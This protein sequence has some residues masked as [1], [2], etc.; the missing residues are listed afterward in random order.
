MAGL[1]R[2]RG[3]G[4]SQVHRSEKRGRASP[5]SRGWTFVEDMCSQILAG[6]PALAGMDPTGYPGE[7]LRSRLPRARGDGPRPRPRQR[8]ISPAS[9]RSRGWTRRRRRPDSRRRGF[10][11][12]AGMDRANTRAASCIAGL[13]RA[14]GDGPATSAAASQVT[15]A[16]PR[17]R[18]WTR[19]LVHA[20][21]LLDGFPALAGM[22]PP[23]PRPAALFRR[24]PRARGDGPEYGIRPLEARAASPRS[25]GWTL[26]GLLRLL[27]GRGFPALAGMDPADE[28]SAGTWPGLPRARGDGPVD[29]D[30][31]DGC[32]EASPRSRGW[33]RLGGE[34]VV[35]CQGFPALAGMDPSQPSAVNVSSGLPRARGDGPC[36]LR[37]SRQPGAASPRSRGWTSESAPHQQSLG[38]FP[39]LAGMDPDSPRCRVPRCRLPRARGDGPPVSEGEHVMQLAS[40]RSRG[41]TLPTAPVPTARRGFPALAGMD[42]ATWR[43]RRR[44]GWLPRARGDGPRATLISG[45]LREASPRSRGWTGCDSMTERDLLGFPALAGMDPGFAVPW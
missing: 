42:P 38:G 19:S 45:S 33:T 8:T 28:V 34:E 30:A 36:P 41:W 15:A 27:L 11:A 5:R 23:R 6:F 20:T 26:V 25:R 29:D 12:L 39:A 35:E 40:P 10:P 22:D 2:A 13:P 16:S 7:I 17:S 44:C 18:G 4:P 32:T 9:P 21:R 3:D 43:R 31:G 1:P 24:L 14:R 37:R